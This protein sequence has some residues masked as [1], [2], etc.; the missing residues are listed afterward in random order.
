VLDVAFD[1]DAAGMMRV[2]VMRIEMA[3]RNRVVH[4]VALPPGGGL[5]DVLR[6]QR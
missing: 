1:L 3:V 4:I 5:V 6:R 2:D